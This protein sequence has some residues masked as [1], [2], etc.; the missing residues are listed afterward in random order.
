MDPKV[1]RVKRKVY[2]NEYAVCFVLLTVQLIL[3]R[4]FLVKGTWSVAQQVRGVG[5]PPEQF[6]LG[7]MN[8]LMGRSKRMVQMKTGEWHVLPTIVLRLF[9]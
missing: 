7:I 5:Q 4:P 3:E 8:R 2:Y 9:Y 6:R 1:L